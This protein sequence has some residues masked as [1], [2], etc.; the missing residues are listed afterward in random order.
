MPHLNFTN[1]KPSP[2]MTTN[3]NEDVKEFKDEIELEK[4]MIKNEL[5]LAHFQLPYEIDTVR[6][7]FGYLNAYMSSGSSVK[8]KFFEQYV[9]NKPII[10]KD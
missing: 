8:I 7:F 1:G 3:S 9:P 10:M 6:K 5:E 4:F 2:I